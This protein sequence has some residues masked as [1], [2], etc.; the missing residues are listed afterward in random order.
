MVNNLE[1]HM[2]L[3][4]NSSEGFFSSFQYI[5]SQ[6][7]A[8][9]I[10]CIKGGPGTGKSFMLK[11]VGNHFKEKGYTVE[12]HHCSSDVD[13]LDG[14]L[15]KELKVAMIDG[16]APH[17]ID[18]KTPG[19]V[20]EILDLAKYLDEDKIRGEKE[21]IM[22]ISKEVSLYFN[23]AYKY[24]R[25]SRVVF[26]D[27]ES[28][29]KLAL[30]VS[31]LN[32]IKE[33][34]KH[35]LLPMNVSGVGTSRHL[36][37]TAFTPTGI[38]TFVDTLYKGYN[39]V[40][41]LKGDAGTGSREVLKYIYEE[42]IKRDLYVEAFHDPF[43]PERLEHILLPH[44]SIALLTCNEINKEYFKE[45][46]TDVELQIDMNTI[47]NK[48]ILNKYESEIKYS[49]D[50]FY[51]LLSKALNIL[52]EVKVIRNTLEDIYI[53]SMNFKEIDTIYENII[54]EIMSFQ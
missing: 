38:E 1:R 49:E 48:D 3:G 12:F 8:N 9:K 5:L 19:A 37:A 29:N 11:K 43:I 30:N 14:I 34:L 45:N 7:E 18:P 10:I 53:S 31:K 35:K 22:D 2:F 28:L 13:S 26:E 44:L 23:R 17:S 39:T 21:R 42:A 15:I 50:I 32:L 20:D 51:E 27:L 6:K 47:L 36:F 24:L 25:A 33:D 40:Y 54:T 52:S 16:T 46:L 4:S 41:L